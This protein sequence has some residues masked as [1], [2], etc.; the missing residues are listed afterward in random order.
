M[1]NDLLDLDADRQHVRKRNRPFAACS[2]PIWQGLLML[3]TLLS[4]SF[5]MSFLLHN[6][7]KL[8]LAAYFIMTL[9]YSIRLKR[10]VIVKV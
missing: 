9:A 1:L 4:A 3:P 2:I 7:F 6:H 10:Q 5:A 8:V